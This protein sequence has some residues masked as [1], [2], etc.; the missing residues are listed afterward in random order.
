M[1]GGR[2]LGHGVCFRRPW[3]SPFVKA[4]RCVMYF[5]FFFGWLMF[6]CNGPASVMWKGRVFQVTYQGQHGFHR[7]WTWPILDS[8]STVDEVWSLHV[9]MSGY[10]RGIAVTITISVSR[11]LKRDSSSFWARGTSPSSHWGVALTAQSLE[12]TL[13]TLTYQLADGD[14]CW[15]TVSQHR[16]KL[17]L[18][19]GQW[20]RALVTLH[21]GARHQR[22]SITVRRIH[23]SVSKDLLPPSCVHD[24]FAEMT[25]TTS[26]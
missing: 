11:L 17:S 20:P 14:W 2:F 24:N 13:W 16:G 22:R 9:W 18:E 21:H 12:E 10:Y 5:R 25:W 6:A 4:L 19:K 26:T 15:C 23:F 7:P 3:L 8:G 1:K